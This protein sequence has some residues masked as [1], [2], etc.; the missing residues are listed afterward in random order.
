MATR[1]IAA[2]AAAFALLSLPAAVASATTANTSAGLP[3]W[4]QLYAQQTLNREHTAAVFP[5]LD[6]AARNIDLSDFGNN[7]VSQVSGQS[8]LG[9]QVYFTDAAGAES[10]YI[11]V[12]GPTTADTPAAACR[13]FTRCLQRHETDGSTT[14]V[15]EYD[16]ATP[17]GTATTRIAEHLRT[18]GTLVLAEEFNFLPIRGDGSPDGAIRSTFPLTVDQLLTLARD[19][20]YKI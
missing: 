10:V 15:V 5:K 8:Y 2:V 7:R 6:P 11:Q 13:N 16:E 12:S 17:Q 20:A 4:D 18:D 1:A 3:T 9:G 14:V 19:H